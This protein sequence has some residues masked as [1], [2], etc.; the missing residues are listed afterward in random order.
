[1]IPVARAPLSQASLDELKR[2]T[3]KDQGIVRQLLIAPPTPEFVGTLKVTEARWPQ[4]KARFDELRAAPSR[5]Q[6][7]AP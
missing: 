3:D 1:M 4:L 7:H 6:P 2:L 5:S